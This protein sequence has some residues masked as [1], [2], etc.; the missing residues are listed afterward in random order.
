MKKEREIRQIVPAAPGWYL[1]VPEQVPNRVAIACFALVWRKRDNDLGD[2]TVEPM[3]SDF[4]IVGSDGELEIAA[5]LYKSYKG[6]Y[7]SPE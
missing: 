1:M 3:V 7:Y 5:D 6:P 2:V 4:D